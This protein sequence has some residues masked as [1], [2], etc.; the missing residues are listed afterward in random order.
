MHVACRR[1]TRITYRSLVWKPEVKRRLRRKWVDIYIH[2]TGRRFIIYCVWYI[3]TQNVV[4]F[5]VRCP[6]HIFLCNRLSLGILDGSFPLISLKWIFKRWNMIMQAGFIRLRTGFSEW[7]SVIN[8]VGFLATWAIV[9]CS[10]RTVLHWF[11][12]DTSCYSTL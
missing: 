11:I 6:R 2:I 1:A 8:T 7:L 10:R 4:S 3:F 5:R 9:N 12:D